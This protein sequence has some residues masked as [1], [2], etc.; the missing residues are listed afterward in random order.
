MG[1]ARPARQRTPILRAEH[2]RLIPDRQALVVAENAPP[3][4][5]RLRRCVDGRAGKALLARQRAARGKVGQARNTTVELDER[6]RHAVQYAHQHR[7]H[8]PAP[9]TTGSDD[10]GSGSAPSSAGKAWSW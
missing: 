1:S 8:S 2:I 4:I 3:I 10:A 7:L 9:R 6:T 5:A